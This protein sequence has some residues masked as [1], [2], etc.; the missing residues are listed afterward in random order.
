MF[1][2]KLK[3]T[4]KSGFVNFWRNGWVSL[5]TVLVMSITL[6]VIGSLIFGKAL[7]LSSLG[8]IEDKVDITVYFKTDASEVDVLALKDSL[9][10]LDEVKD[11]HY[12]SRDEALIL[13]KTRHTNNSLIIQSLEELDENP[14]GASLNIKAQ[15]PSQYE[16]IAR[17]L[18]AGVFSA[19]DKIN[20]NQNRL[21]IDRLSNIL[22]TSKNVGTGIS[23]VLTFVALLVTFNTIRLAIYTSKEEIKTMRLVGASNRYV[24]G[25]FIVEGILYGVLASIFT[26]IIFYPLTFWLGSFSERFF[27]GVNVFYYYLTNFVET[28]AILT[29]IGVSLGTFSSWFASRRYLKA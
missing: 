17:F 3:R 12:I 15:N 26:M 14:L 2:V 9:V 13:F 29:L 23:L 6:F 1:F 18:E 11:V 7:L 21:V 16:S 24:R 22:Q 5:A 27:G 10:E 4:V 8:Q 25:P 28:F 20:Y 19:I